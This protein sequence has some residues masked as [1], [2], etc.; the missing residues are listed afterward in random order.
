MNPA[1]PIP[2]FEA[3]SSLI[4]PGVV[5]CLLPTGIYIQLSVHDSITLAN[6]KLALWK[7]AQKY[8]L[9]HRLEKSR[10]YVFVGVSSEAPYVQEFYDESRC[11]RDLRLFLSFFQLK[12]VA[13][14]RE[15]KETC[16]VI[17]TSTCRYP[18]TSAN[19]YKY[20][21]ARLRSIWLTVILFTRQIT[22]VWVYM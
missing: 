14:N 8:P 7:E 10:E 15:E 3:Q 17:G 22:P 6:L 19:T 18:N 12:E 13:G 1:V 11:V 20:C 4:I 21:L 9:F 5:E 2:H 16:Q